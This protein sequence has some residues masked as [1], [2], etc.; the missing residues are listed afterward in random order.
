MSGLG[1][2]FL[3]RPSESHET[4]PRPG[5]SPLEYAEF[6]STLK[7]REVALKYPHAVTLGA[8]TIVVLDGE[9]IGKPRDKNHALH[10]LGQ[11][12]GRS[13]EVITSCCIVLPEKQI[14]VKFSA[15]SLVWLAEQDPNIIRAYVLTGEPLDKAGS[16]AVQGIG[17]FMVERIEGSYSNIVGLPL[18]KVVQYFLELGVIKYQVF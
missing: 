13:H 12:V 10:M 6:N 7:A 11:L 8:D 18:D 3:I 4:V 14:I 17:S 9:I 15:S 16:Y 1:L 5:E 2:D